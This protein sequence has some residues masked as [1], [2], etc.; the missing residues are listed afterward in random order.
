MCFEN[1]DDCFA[2]GKLADIAVIATQDKDHYIPAMKA[3][4]LG[5]DIM[6]E[7]PISPDPKECAEIAQYAKEKG[8]RIVVC[9]VLRYT[10]FFGKI[11]QLFSS[12]VINCLVV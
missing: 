4:S 6:L 11:K 7:K 2:K 3:I 5:Y 1:W 12:F 8:V 9:H 10:P